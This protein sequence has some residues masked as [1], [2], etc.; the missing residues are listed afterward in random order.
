M[1]AGAR[2]VKPRQ[3]K[4]AASSNDSVKPDNRGAHHIQKPGKQHTGN[5]RP[6]TTAPANDDLDGRDG[7]RSGKDDDGNRGARTAVRANRPAIAEPTAGS[8][9]RTDC[10]K[11]GE[12]GY[13]KFY[14][15]KHKAQTAL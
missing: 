3:A 6:R 14:L 11:R 12:N 2:S 15:F 5:G 13:D 10:G 7:K 8:T 1:V 9:R 4:Y